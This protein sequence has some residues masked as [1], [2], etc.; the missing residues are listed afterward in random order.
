MILG[1]A[2]GGH[3]ARQEL[4][5]ALADPEVVQPAGPY[6]WH[7][8]IHACHLVGEPALGHELMERYW[9]TMLDLGADTFW[10]VFNPADHFASPYENPQLNSYC[11][12]WSCTPSWFLRAPHESARA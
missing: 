5:A 8:V 2:S 10:E 4:R 9:G 6:L 1:G 7:H 3:E 11:H 12:A